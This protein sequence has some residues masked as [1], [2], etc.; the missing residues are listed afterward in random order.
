MW[1]NCY[2][3]SMLQTNLKGKVFIASLDSHTPLAASNCLPNVSQIILCLCG[4]DAINCTNSSTYSQIVSPHKCLIVFYSV[5][6][7]KSDRSSCVKNERR[8][9]TFTLPYFDQ[10]LFK[11]GMIVTLFVSES[12]KNVSNAALPLCHQTGGF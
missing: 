7:M 1:T 2:D 3:V 5:V 9:I 8:E 11:V 12:Y 6:H 10:S 4:L